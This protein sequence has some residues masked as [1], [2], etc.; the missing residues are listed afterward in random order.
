MWEEYFGNDGGVYIA[1]SPMKSLAELD[2]RHTAAKKAWAGT[3]D[4]KKKKMSDL[5]ASSFASVHTNLYSMD[6]KMSYPPDRWKTASP[7]FWGKQ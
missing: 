3:S 6:P 4:D 2:E 1:T 5:E 7:D